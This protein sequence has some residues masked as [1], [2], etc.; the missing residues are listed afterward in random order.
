[1][2]VFKLSINEVDH[3]GL[4]LHLLDDVLI[5]SKFVDNKY[6]KVFDCKIERVD[7]E[8][9]TPYFVEAD[10]RILIS[11]RA[12]DSLIKTIEKYKDVVLLDTVSNLLGNVFLVGKNCV[13]YSS[14]KK[15]DVESI[16]K[17]MELPAK[18]LKSE[19]NLGSV[20]KIYKDKAMASQ[21]LSD[22][23]LD[24]IKDCLGVRDFDIG[25]VNLGSPYLR[26]GIELND[27]Y[28]VVGERTTGHE[29]IRIEE[30]FTSKSRRNE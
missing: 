10:D 21:L 13:L 25:S 29:L 9:I 14:A 1:M 2:R 12:P 5:A 8:L 22:R 17:V 7:S 4:F 15:R 28:L 26:Y 18:R 20:V 27:N 30:F 11:K 6:L 23:Q 16:V 19:Y 3:I 24:V